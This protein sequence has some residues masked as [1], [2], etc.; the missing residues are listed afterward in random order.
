MNIK[1]LSTKIVE[2][3]KVN[4]EYLSSI[5]KI[6]KINFHQVE[7]GEYIL[8]IGPKN[9]KQYQSKGFD[10]DS[11]L[12]LVEVKFY[13]AE[14]ENLSIISVSLAEGVN[15]YIEDII[16]TASITEIDLKVIPEIDSC[17]ITY[18]VYGTIGDNYKL[19]Q[20]TIKL[21]Q[22]ECCSGQT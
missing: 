5:S 12:S 8:G 13:T 21:M 1:E 3:T 2:L 22:K 7:Q 14:G 15:V 19:T 4:T 9:I 11:I 18:P 20:I 17:L 6:L 10:S 16:D